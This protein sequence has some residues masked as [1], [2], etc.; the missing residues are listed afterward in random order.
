MVVSSSMPSLPWTTQA[1]SAA[2]LAQHL[3]HRPDPVAREH[4]G[5]LA[6]GAGGVRERAHQVEDGAGAQLDPRRADMAH[7]AMMARRHHEADVGVPQRLPHQR[8]VGIDIDAECAPARRPRRSWT[9]GRDCHA[10]PPARRRR[11]PRWRPPV[12]MFQVPAASPPVPQVSMAPAGASMRVIL[13]RMAR[14]APVISSTVSPR[15][16]SA[17]RKPPI[18]D[19]VALPD[20]M[21]SN[22]ASAC[23]R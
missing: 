4:A 12:E 18:C 19:G 15:T 6:L 11:P 2:E 16:R 14:T 22:A 7:G 8:H 17:I 23:S 13:P 1:R 20:I 5:Q 10:W 21:M 9:T 3:G